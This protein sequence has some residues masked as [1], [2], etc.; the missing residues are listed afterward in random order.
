MKS[1][2]RLLG[3][4]MLVVGCAA[5]ARVAML[6]EPVDRA[7][8]SASAASGGLV[9]LELYVLDLRLAPLLLAVAGVGLLVAPFV[10]TL[11][12]GALAMSAAAGAAL[13][14]PAG[15]QLLSAWWAGAVVLVAVLA[16]IA[17]LTIHRF[18]PA[19]PRGDAEALSRPARRVTATIA[20]VLLCSSLP[21]EVFLDF[22]APVLDA[23]PSGYL[24]AV[25]V[26]QGLALGSGMLAL[27]LAARRLTWLHAV[28]SCMAL[29]ELAALLTTNASAAGMALTLALVVAATAAA[30]AGERG[31]VRCGAVALAAC[32]ALAYP[33]V[34]FFA[35]FFGFGIGTLPLALNGGVIDYDGLPVFL[36]GPLSA[37][38]PVL[39]YLACS[40]APEATATVRDAHDLQSPPTDVTADV[41]GH[42]IG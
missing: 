21:M 25:P 16:G 27:L 4:V 32:L 3:L 26:L 33:V 23:L 18:R 1:V 35:F 13:L 11:L 15:A 36:G 30:V 10:P 40:G 34:G 39:L 29:A 42:P 28:A 14:V 38:L 8:A 5:W 31:R 37:A 24:V 12:D 17:T 41:S 20:L 7:V 6:E 2:V 9:E 19:K 22:D